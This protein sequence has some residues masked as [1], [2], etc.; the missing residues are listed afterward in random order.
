MDDFITGIGIKKPRILTG[1]SDIDRLT[2][3]LRIPSVS[4]IG[5]APSTGKTALALNMAIRQNCPVLIFSLEMSYDMI[6]ERLVSNLMSIDYNLF[7]TQEFTEDDL[8]RVKLCAEDLKKRSIYIYDEVYDIEGQAAIIN[9]IKPSLVV[10][11]YIQKVQTK[12]RTENR[13][14]EV[15]Y[16]S[17]Q[18]KQLATHNN[19]H[20]MLLSQISR[21]DRD[22]PTM[23]SLK[24][25]GALE[26]DGDYVMLLHRPYVMK[27]ELG[28]PDE[29]Y[30]LIDKNKFGGTGKVGL[31]FEGK[32]QRFLLFDGYT[33]IKGGVPEEW[34]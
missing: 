25:S 28:N 32:Y 16:I 31:R 1:F 6:V 15:D 33:E 27:K 3:G 22:L 12:K 24:E 21:L 9:S 7:S 2:G 13:R 20:I 8:K 11:D 4:I 34:K 10:V 5:A 23:S 29:A 19:C 18:Y 17:G 30:L 26:A 14:N